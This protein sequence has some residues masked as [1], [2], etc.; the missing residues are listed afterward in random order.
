MKILLL[1]PDSKIPNL[2]LMKISTFH[3][4]KGDLVGFNIPVPDLIYV[5]I[6]FNKNKLLPNSIKRMFPEAKI[7]AGGP[8][9]DPK[10][11]LPPEIE[12][13]P[14]D[15]T[16]WPNSK[17]SVGRVTSGC[18]RKC[19]FCMVHVQEPAGIRYIQHPSQIWK[20]GTILRLIDDNILAMPEAF[21]EVYDFCIKNNVVLHM[22]YWDI[23]LI[24]PVAAGQIAVLNHEQSIWFSFDYEGIEDQVRRGIKNLFDAGI[25]PYKLRCL[26]FLNDESQIESAKR[27]WT[28]LRDLGVDPFLMVNIDNKTKNLYRIQK[29]ACRPGI[30]RHLSTEEVF[31]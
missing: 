19:P 13:L 10:I 15:Q 14:P 7:I 22:E 28:I 27:R 12:S 18:I 8:G 24:D 30:Y 16:L 31:R 20:P 29:R 2:A 4:A 1:A 3:K 21:N 9:Y 6:I 5:S 26:V 11:L 25:K 23:Q 17:Y